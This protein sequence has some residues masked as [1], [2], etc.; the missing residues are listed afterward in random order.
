[1]LAVPL[2]NDLATRRRLSEAAIRAFLSLARVWSLTVDEQ[3]ELLG[4]SISRSTLRNWAADPGAVLSADQLMRVSFL[5]AIYEGLQRIWRRA[6]TEADAWLRRPNPESPFDGR[7]PLAFIREGGIPALALARGYID[8]ATGGP[9]S[10]ADHQP[11]VSAPA[12]GGTAL[13]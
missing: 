3:L 11:V 10:R 1:M 4:A 5:L 6:P 7:T 8:A 2:V 13:A 9:P 12:S